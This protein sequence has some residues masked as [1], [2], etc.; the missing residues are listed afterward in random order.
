M[1]AVFKNAHLDALTSGN[2]LALC[3]FWHVFGQQDALVGFCY[4]E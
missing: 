2:T 3:Q 4:T 1:A